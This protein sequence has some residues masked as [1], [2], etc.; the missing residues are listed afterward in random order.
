MPRDRQPPCYPLGT[1]SPLE[2]SSFT[3]RARICSVLPRARTP[4]ALMWRGAVALLWNLHGSRGPATMS[5]VSMWS[6]RKPNLDGWLPTSKR[7]P[8]ACTP[9]WC[10]MRLPSLTASRSTFMLP[11]RWLWCA[12][13]GMLPKCQEWLT[14]ARRCSMLSSG[15]A[16]CWLRRCWTFSI[17][18]LMRR[19]RKL[20]T[21]AVSWALPWCPATSAIIGGSEVPRRVRR[22]G[23]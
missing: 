8:R 10:W 4:T 15:G 2:G 20:W 11:L 3:R 7:G 6:C 13:S 9:R 21:H 12:R 23:R 5:G 17:T 22:W 18:L 14:L 1:C 16:V 19:W